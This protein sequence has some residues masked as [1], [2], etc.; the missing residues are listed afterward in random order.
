MMRVRPAR[1]A[2]LPAVAQVFRACFTDS[3]AGVVPSSV[4]RAM[5]PQRALNLW[6]AALADAG[7]T[8]VADDD[9][10]GVVGVTRVG[11]PGPEGTGEVASLYVAPAAQGQGIGQALMTAALERLRELGAHRAQLWV[12]ATNPGAQRLYQ[13]LGYRADGR[14]R[15]EPAYGVVELGMSLDLAEVR[16]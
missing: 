8:L 15:V 9:A 14:T 7:N 1:A 16:P 6:E 2:D 4:R 3:Y 13:K 10:A 11:G 5:T 12:F